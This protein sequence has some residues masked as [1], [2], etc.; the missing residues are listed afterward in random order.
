MPVH[1]TI[2]PFAVHVPTFKPFPGVSVSIPV[3]NAMRS[4]PSVNGVLKAAMVASRECGVFFG[5]YPSGA[6]IVVRTV[7]E[8]EDDPPVHP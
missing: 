2:F 7:T 8:E 4:V 1:S 6:L 5:R 3:G